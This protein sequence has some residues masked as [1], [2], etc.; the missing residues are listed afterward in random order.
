MLKLYESCDCQKNNISKKE[1]FHEKNLAPQH[2]PKRH[3]EERHS[4]GRLRQRDN[5]QGCETTEL[6]SAKCRSV[7]C[8]FAECRCAEILQCKC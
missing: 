7:L 1:Y 8:R 2:S 4:A 5:E 6:R 3:F